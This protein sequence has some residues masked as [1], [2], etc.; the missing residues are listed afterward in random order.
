MLMTLCTS[1][2]E[3]PACGI[4]T[5][6]SSLN[7][8]SSLVHVGKE[9]L[10]VFVIFGLVSAVIVHHNSQHNIRKLTALPG[11]VSVTVDNNKNVTDRV[12]SRNVSV[13]SDLD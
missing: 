1:S 4:S 5:G 9:Y 7:S 3:E 10:N 6:T 2:L 8:T 13:M 11:D 12:S